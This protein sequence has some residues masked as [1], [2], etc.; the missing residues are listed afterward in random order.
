[1]GVSPSAY[2]VVP[3]SLPDACSVAQSVDNEAVEWEDLGPRALA[4]CL[5]S[6][7]ELDL[8]A[9]LTAVDKVTSDGPLHG[10]AQAVVAR[11]GRL[12]ASR[13][14]ELARAR[15]RGALILRRQLD[16]GS[17]AGLVLQPPASPDLLG[18]CIRAHVALQRN[19]EG[20]LTNEG[21]EKLVSRAYPDAA[22]SV[23]LPMVADAVRRAGPASSQAIRLTP[24]Q[25]ALATDALCCM[26]HRQLLVFAFLCL[27]SSC[28]DA[29]APQ[30]A[31]ADGSSSDGFDDARSAPAISVQRLCRPE[32]QVLLAEAAGDLDGKGQ[33]LPHIAPSSHANAPL[34]QTLRRAAAGTLARFQADAR[35]LLAGRARPGTAAGGTTRGGG[36]GRHWP[37]PPHHRSASSD[38]LRERTGTGTGGGGEGARALDV[39]RRLVHGRIAQALRLGDGGD[40]GSPEAS[41][42]GYGG[43][44][45]GSAAVG[46][47]GDADEDGEGGSDGDAADDDDDGSLPAPTSRAADVLLLEDWLRLAHSAPFAFHGLL[48]CRDAL[49]GASGGAARWEAHRA[50]W[51]RAWEGKAGADFAPFGSPQLLS[52]QAEWALRSA[53][54]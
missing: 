9:S 40:S 26:S 5:R 16:L 3:V 37:A 11:A 43:Q 14:Q 27:A 31:P 54:G 18:R 46:A 41:A 7:R 15:R 17:F 28:G 36:G 30:H 33:L 34:V 35:S 23:W 52:W 21:L 22:E 25:S 53:R 24:E 4:C 19:A 51:E 10:G 38:G 1:M 29:F 44:A 8:A 20:Y 12:C 42:R 47:D 2:V 6:L 48:A 39:K 32:V 13:A 49:A 50:S 45:L